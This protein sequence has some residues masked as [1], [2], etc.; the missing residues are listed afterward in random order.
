MFHIRFSQYDAIVDPLKND[1]M[2]S[3]IYPA[4]QREIAKV[5]CFK[6]I[7]NFSST[8]PKSNT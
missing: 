7:H 8:H 2:I 5:H 4:T 3:M 6:T 1:L